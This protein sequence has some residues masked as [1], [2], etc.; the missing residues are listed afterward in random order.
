MN[1]LVPLE[2]DGEVWVILSETPC[3]LQGSCYHSRSLRIAASAGSTSVTLNY[4]QIHSGA[5]R[6]NAILDR[7]GNMAETGFPD[8]GDG[9]SAP[10]AMVSVSEGGG[11]SAVATILLDL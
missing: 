5:Y 3:D 9:I 11:S 2:A 8:S 4:D 1:W 6:M 7:N 10:N